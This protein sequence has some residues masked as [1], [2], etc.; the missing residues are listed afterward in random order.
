MTPEPA[1]VIDAQASRNS[2]LVLA[3][4]GPV[5][6]VAAGT[7]GAIFLGRLRRLP[8]L[9]EFAERPSGWVAT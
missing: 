1:P 2:M 5:V 9:P 4:L 7:V 8:L 6:G 3:L